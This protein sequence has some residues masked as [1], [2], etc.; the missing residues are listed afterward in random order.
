MKKLTLLLIGST[1]LGSIHLAGCASDGTMSKQ[2]VGVLTGAA[3]GGLVG[4]RFGGGSGQVAATLAGGALGAFI[5][6]SIGQ[7]MDNA[8]R[9]RMSQTFE[10]APTNRT[11]AWR[12][13]DNGNAYQVTPMKTYQDNSG[14]PCREYSSVAIIGGKRQQVYG[15]ACRQADGAWKVIQ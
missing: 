6:G 9:M 15:T 14:Q 10:S 12:N 3:L 5:G 2:N 7:S 1:L 13:P 11:V 4:S 8:D